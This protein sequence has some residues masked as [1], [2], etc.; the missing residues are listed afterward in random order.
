MRPTRFTEFEQMQKEFIRL[1]NREAALVK[2]LGFVTD[3]LESFDGAVHFTRTDR[4]ALRDAR[5]ILANKK[6]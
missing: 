2:V 5:K 4:S 1:R 3:R 6:G